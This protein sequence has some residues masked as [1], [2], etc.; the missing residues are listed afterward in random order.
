MIAQT[1]R[2]YNHKCELPSQQAVMSQAISGNEQLP[3]GR[4]KYKLGACSCCTLRHR[5]GI[6][7]QML[8]Y[9]SME[10]TRKLKWFLVMFL[11]VIQDWN[12]G[13]ENGYE[14]NVG[15]GTMYHS[16]HA[17]RLPLK[18]TEGFTDRHCGK[19]MSLAYI[20]LSQLDA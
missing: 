19:N 18:L 13:E 8:N 2:R 4:L 7:M 14:T 5:H 20:I 17:H 12:S 10:M 9:Y 11:H 1:I 6:C 3:F 16:Q 15:R